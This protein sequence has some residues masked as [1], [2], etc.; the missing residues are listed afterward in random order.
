MGTSG[1]RCKRPLC[2]IKKPFLS[3][4]GG[5]RGHRYQWG[6]VRL[7]RNQ[8]EDPRGDVRGQRPLHM[9][10]VLHSGRSGRIRVGD[11][12]CLGHRYER[13]RVNGDFTAPRRRAN[14]CESAEDW[15]ITGSA[16][17]ITCSPLYNLLD[18]R[19]CKQQKES[20]TREQ[21]RI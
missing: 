12:R 2:G 6:Q 4:P 8:T 3:F 19:V 18:V 15:K 7:H 16:T 9:H 14:S 17:V 20:W 5:L 11:H 1:H 13:I 21:T 10:A